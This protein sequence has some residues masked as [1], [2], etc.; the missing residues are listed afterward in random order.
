MLDGVPFGGAG[1]IVGH[2]DRQGKRVGQ[3]R[4]ELGLRFVR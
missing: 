2:G 4:L 3:S 1:W